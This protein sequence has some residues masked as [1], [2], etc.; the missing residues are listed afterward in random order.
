MVYRYYFT[1]VLRPKASVLAS[2]MA[3]ILKKKGVKAFKAAH[4]IYELWRSGK[5]SFNEA[6][7]AIEMILN[8]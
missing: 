4:D 2:L 6:L 1:S 8:E 5:I 3:K 7:K